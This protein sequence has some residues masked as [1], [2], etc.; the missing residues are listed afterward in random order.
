MT[1][2]EGETIRVKVTA[3]DFDGEAIT[4]NAATPPVG[5]IEVYDSDLALVFDADLTWDAVLE[6]W[7]Y[8]YQNAAAGSFKVKAKFVGATPLAYETWEIARLAIKESPV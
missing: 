7:Y 2:F 4:G 1:K 6:Y 5:T 3:T 8:D